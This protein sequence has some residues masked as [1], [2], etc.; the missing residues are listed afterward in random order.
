MRSGMWWKAL[1]VAALAVGPAWAIGD[2]EDE[3]V[4]AQDE[5]DEGAATA[6]AVFEYLMAELAAQRGDT[7]S[8]MAIG[9]PVSPACNVRSASRSTRRPGP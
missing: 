5:A 3:A 4:E 7:T 6:D 1:L 9:C 8:A 2:N